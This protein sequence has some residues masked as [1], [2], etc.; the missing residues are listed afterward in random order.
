MTIPPGPSVNGP[1]PPPPQGPGNVTGEPPTS[2]NLSSSP[3]AKMFPGGATPKQFT[4]FINQ[5]LKDM[6]NDFKRDQEEWHKAQQRL[7]QIE[8][9]NDPDS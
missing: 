1:T 7:K 6:C 4:Q 8:E 5:F 3:W 9:G 2:Q